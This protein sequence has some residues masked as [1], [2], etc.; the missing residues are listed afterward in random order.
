MMNP[1]Q[2]VKMMRGGNPQKVVM[3]M[4]REQAGNNPVM[5]NAMQMAEKGDSEGIE[6]LA[7]NLCKE[8]GIDADEMVNKIKSQFGV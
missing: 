5:R 8:Q 6:K 4:M 7:R 3:D 1:V 2:F